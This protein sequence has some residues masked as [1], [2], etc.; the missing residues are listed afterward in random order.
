MIHDFKYISKHAP[1]V[2]SA[3]VEIQAIIREVQR[4]LE[5]RITFMPYVV[6]S[7]KRNM[8]TCDA[9]SNVGFD[10]DFNLQLNDTENLKP[11]QIKDMLRTAISRSAIRFG[12][13]AAEDSTRVITIKQINQK[14]SRIFHSCDFAITRQYEDEEYLYEDFL[15]FDK[16][17]NRYYWRKQNQSLWLLPEKIEYLKSLEDAP[18]IW[19]ELRDLYIRNKN[20]NEDPEIH[21]RDI[22]ARTVHTMCQRYG[23]Y[24]DK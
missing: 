12:Y 6:G 20:K 10:F 18:A 3:Y 11:K 2:K 8:L 5:T 16:K 9:K 21:S 17:E 14:S 19:Q 7:Y 23:Y 1:E 24:E 22:L 4:N 13:K 15:Y